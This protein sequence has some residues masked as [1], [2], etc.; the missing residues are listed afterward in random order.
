MKNIQQFILEY[1]EWNPILKTHKK[2]Y[3]DFVKYYNKLL[4]V[5]SKEEILD[6]LNGLINEIK[7]ENHLLK[8]DKLEPID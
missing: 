3:N 5:M 4:Y 1:E 2:A 6:M 8:D 7:D